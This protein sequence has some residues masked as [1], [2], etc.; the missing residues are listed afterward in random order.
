M[1]VYSGLGNNLPYDLELNVCVYGVC[2]RQTT[3]WSFMNS[4]QDLASAL[5]FHGRLDSFQSVRQ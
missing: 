3:S 5:G 4:K 1:S 2:P